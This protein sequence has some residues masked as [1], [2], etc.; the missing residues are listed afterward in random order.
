MDKL[1]WLNGHYIKTLLPDDIAGRLA[2]FIEKVGY[3]AG[4][5]DKLLKIVAILKERA[6]TLKEMAQM[7]EFFFKEDIEYEAKAKE[8]YLTAAT[9]PRLERF[10]RDFSELPSLGESEQRAFV[11]GIAGRL[12]R[13][14][15]TSF[16][17]SG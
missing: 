7:A 14:S 5:R 8:K 13:K 10:L 6:K 3:P 1:L 2:P 12:G 4:D 17:P 15:S 11:E 16:S 9:K